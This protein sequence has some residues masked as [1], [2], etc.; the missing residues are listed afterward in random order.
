LILV[1]INHVLLLACFRMIIIFLV[2]NEIDFFQITCLNL[3]VENEI[4][5]FKN[6]M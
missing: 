1:L 2:E 3:H 5:F 6:H 4:D